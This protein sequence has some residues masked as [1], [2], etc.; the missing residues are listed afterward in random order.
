MTP[1]YW[2]QLV[3]YREIMNETGPLFG[4]YATLQRMNLIHIQ[5]ELEDI[6]VDLMQ[7]ETTTERQMLRL[8]STMHEYG[9]YTP[10]FI[11]TSQAYNI[12]QLTPS[13]T[14]STWTSL[15]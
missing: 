7:Y 3:A 11:S 10:K 15:K 9:M 1:E 14:L 5:N 8:R 12:G 4:E 2:K 6:K 13:V